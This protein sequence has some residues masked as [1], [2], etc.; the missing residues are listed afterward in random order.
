MTPLL[1]KMKWHINVVFGDREYLLLW[2][3]ATTRHY[4]LF[5]ELCNEYLIDKRHLKNSGW[6]RNTNRFLCRSHHM[7]ILY[8]SDSFLNDGGE[9]SSI[10]PIFHYISQDPSLIFIYLHPRHQ[11]EIPTPPKPS[12]SRALHMPSHLWFIHFRFGNLSLQS[13]FSFNVNTP[14]P[15]NL[16]YKYLLRDMIISPKHWNLRLPWQL[17][18]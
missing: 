6:S 14:Q 17:L 16:S 11:V 3:L 12:P 5:N 13:F 18:P 10:T 9:Y 4:L 15:H 2:Q 8:I 1:L 7:E